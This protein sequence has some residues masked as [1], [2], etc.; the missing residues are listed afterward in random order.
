MESSRRAAWQERHRAAAADELAAPSPFV[1]RALDVLGIP[2][3]PPRALDVACGRGRHAV[4][5]ATRGYRVQAVDFAMSAIAPLA[6]TAAGR[7][8]PIECIVADL[9]DWPVPVARYA[10]VLVVDFLARPLFPAFRAAVAPGGALLY[11]T[12]R[13]TADPSAPPAVRA[14]YQLAPGE[15][16]ELCRGFDV[17]MREDTQ[18]RHHGTPAFRAGILARR[19]PAPPH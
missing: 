14:D 18:T 4:L 11:E 1:V 15:L 3:P 9:D 16:D 19:P 17:L 8:L 2:R 13:R 7:A 12:H 10:L 5:L 6:R